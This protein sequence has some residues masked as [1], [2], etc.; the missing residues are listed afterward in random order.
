MALALVVLNGLLQGCAGLLD[1]RARFLE[2]WRP[3]RVVQIDQ[4]AAIHVRIAKDCRKMVAPDAA[5][6]DR[7]VLVRYSETPSRCAYRVAPLSGAETIE[8]G[9]RVQVNIQHCHAPLAM[10]GG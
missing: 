9:D 10:I 1:E 4:G 2:G 6:R 3:G 5:A 8:V 7:Y